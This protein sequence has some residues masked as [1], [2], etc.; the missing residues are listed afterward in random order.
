ML[1]KLVTL[2]KIMF[3]KLAHTG[4]EGNEKA[5]ELTKTGASAPRPL[6]AKNLLYASAGVM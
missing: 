1:N 5:D 2:N 3:Y 6:A 4:I